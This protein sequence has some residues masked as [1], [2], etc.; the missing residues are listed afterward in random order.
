MIVIESV[1]CVLE[2]PNGG[3]EPSVRSAC[4]IFSFAVFDV[5][6]GEIDDAQSCSV[7]KLDPRRE[8]LDAVGIEETVF[9]VSHGRNHVNSDSSR[10][11][12]HLDAFVPLGDS[13]VPVVGSQGLENIGSE[14]WPPISS[15]RICVLLELSLGCIQRRDIFEKCRVRQNDRVNIAVAHNVRCIRIRPLEKDIGV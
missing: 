7:S 2:H 6:F 10:P 4:R 9:L 13:S 5:L 3:F 8:R 14:I 1:S 15:R 11:K 12:I